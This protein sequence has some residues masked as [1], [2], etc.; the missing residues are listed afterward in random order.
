LSII[1]PEPGGRLAESE[2]EQVET[3]LTMEE[4][5]QLAGNRLIEQS[6]GELGGKGGLA[7]ERA[8]LT[9]KDHQVGEILVHAGSEM[10][11]ASLSVVR[12]GERLKAEVE[13]KGS[14]L[15]AE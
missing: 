7:G 15:I 5:G 11:D 2:A 8:R 13:K 4:G 9:G 6:A 10:V 12:F 14:G 3:I 1:S